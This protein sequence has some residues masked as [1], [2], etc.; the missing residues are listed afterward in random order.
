MPFDV[1]SLLPALLA[2]G[3]IAAVLGLCLAWGSKTFHVEVDERIAAIDKALPGV[4]CGACGYPGCA[5][6]AEAIVNDDVS[7]T[8]CAPGGSS[9]A[10][11]IAAIMGGDAEGMETNYAV[12]ACQST[13]VVDTYHYSGV[14]DCR[15][16]SLN[17]LA[18]GCKACTYGCLGFGTCVKA[19]PFD[20]LSFDGH[21]S[22]TV[23]ESKCTGCRRCV[24]V[25]PRDI[26]RIEP[27]KHTVHV[28]CMNKSKGA[29]ANKVCLN[30][31]IACKKCE[32][33][34][35]F[36]AIHVIDNLAVIDYEKCKF[37]G[38]CAKVCPKN[39]IVDL[40]KARRKR[41]KKQG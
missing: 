17:G 14:R 26:N 5:G 30:A 33:D 31:C 18:G 15:A 34:C 21:N 4:N 29:V 9:T 38:K 19:C 25:C 40:R 39:A 8:L 3:G 2:M 12:V 28:L 36:D 6:Y 11:A 16:A 32:R 27:E 41:K 24:E 10:E 7:M 22:P 20:A 23:H 35:P 13:S 37:C 1:M